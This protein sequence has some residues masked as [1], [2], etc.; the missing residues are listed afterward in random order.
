MTLGYF[1]ETFLGFKEFAI[2]NTKGRMGP[3]WWPVKAEF[4]DEEIKRVSRW[5]TQA[6]KSTKLM[7]FT[8]VNNEW[9]FSHPWIKES[10]GTRLE[11]THA[12]YV[13]SHDDVF[14]RA[15]IDGKPP[16]LPLMSVEQ[17]VEIARKRLKT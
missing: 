6:E 2:G 5:S 10:D 8:D 1:M 7:V 4:L 17:L 9:V 12:R 3:D 15:T 11:L 16:E 13:L 14:V